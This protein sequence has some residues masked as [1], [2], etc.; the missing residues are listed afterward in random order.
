[1]RLTVL[2]WS[3]LATC[4]FALSQP[5][6]SHIHFEVAS[7]K[8][9]QPGSRDR[10]TI[11]GGPGT[12]DPERITFKSCT[13]K[14]L[15]MYAYA[16]AFDAVTY[17][18]DPIVTG[19]AWLVNGG[20]YEVLAKVPAGSTK[21]QVRI[22]LQNLL[23]DRFKLVIRNEK[24]EVSGYELSVAKGGPK[25][26]ESADPNAPRNNTPFKLDNDQFPVVPEG[27][28]D[29]LQYK[30][31]VTARNQ[32]IEDLRRFLALKLATHPSTI[33]DRTGL[34]RTY[35]FRFRTVPGGPPFPGFVRPPDSVDDG[36][37]IFE[38]L[39]KQLG[40]KLEKKKVF[41]ETFFVEFA[42]RT[43]AEN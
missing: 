9:T 17:A 6:D 1:M 14:Y 12:G 8:T 13:L 43:P 39:Q 18:D 16:P 36:P 32:S 20:T 10:M 26:T 11:A 31:Y 5:A 28:T 4:G 25:L 42:E 37:S 22:M 38:A 40:L 2:F 23:V 24:K 21:D 30:G 3:C 33:I 15:L 27:T 29:L 19:P 41:A 35:D 34:L 7:V